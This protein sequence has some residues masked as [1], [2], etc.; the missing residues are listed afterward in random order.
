MTMIQILEGSGGGSNSNIL[1]EN[2][3][4]PRL[5]PQLSS[6]KSDGQGNREFALGKK[7][8]SSM[9]LNHSSLLC[10]HNRNGGYSSFC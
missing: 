4:G 10:E 2:R 8:N 6:E 3:P 9:V 7:Q 5:F 1:I